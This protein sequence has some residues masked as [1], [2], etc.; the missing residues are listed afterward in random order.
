MNQRELQRL[1]TRRAL[2]AAA[3]EL[4]ST[5]GF[6]QTTVEDITTLAG[7][8]PRTF[9]LHFPNKASVAFPDH[10]ERVELF[11]ANL[12]RAGEHCDPL[13]HIFHIFRTTLDFD[14]PTRKLRYALLATVD[15]LRVEDVRTDR[16]YEDAI[17]EFLSEAWGTTPESSLRARAT[18]N[19]VIAVLR[20]ALVAWSESGINPAEAAWELL[21]RMFGVPMSIPLH[22]VQ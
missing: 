11:R 20:A 8:S 1:E 16:D 2:A 19:A 21:T 5:R 12:G 13:A 10:A 6:E 14:S 9:F 15:E 18:A 17:A 7:V 22:A 4:F 3:L